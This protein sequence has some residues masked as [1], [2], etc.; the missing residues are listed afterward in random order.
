MR[1]GLENEFRRL[2]ITQKNGKPNHPQ[3]RGTVERFQQT[4]KKWL[5]AQ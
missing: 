5:T 3:T 2:R 1:N 4:M